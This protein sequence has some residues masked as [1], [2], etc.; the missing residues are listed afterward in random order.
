MNLTKLIRHDLQCGLFR[1]RC[2]LV[3][4]LAA[5]PCLL[6]LRITDSAGCKSSWAGYMMYCFMGIEPISV[7]DTMEKAQ[8]PILWL[9]LIIG[10][11]YLHLDYPLND[12][13]LTGQQIIVRSGNRR[14][15]YLAKCV[16]NLCACG[17]YFLMVSLTASLF[18]VLTG[19]D[20]S[21]NC[22]AAALKVL[23]LGET[24]GK[25]LPP[26]TAL[27][28]SLILPYL[29]VSAI[30][31]LQMTL[32]LIMKPIFCFLIGIILL[33]LSVYWDSPLI[34]GNGAMGIRSSLLI[35]GGVA[36][37][38][39]AEECCLIIILCMAIGSWMFKRSDI[40]SARE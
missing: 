22:D 6:C 34:L 15:W 17:L 13:S 37:G 16:W 1:L 10:C 20:L 18:T 23:Y 25:T 12:L 24:G 4:P 38:P 35:S 30:S 32:C 21:L 8:F 28:L 7:Q 26:L 40:L 36:P 3:P 31:L 29:T 9:I 19:G 27:L 5:L 39:A 11:L 14:N 2:L 33:L